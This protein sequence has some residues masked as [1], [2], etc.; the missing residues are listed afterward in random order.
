MTPTVLFVGGGLET[1][2]AIRRAQAMG[3]RVVVS[4]RDPQA[5]GC[6]IADHALIASAYHPDETVAAVA[7]FHRDVCR[8]DAALAVA[9]DCPHSVAAV[10]AALGLP[11]ITPEVGQRAVDKLAM[12]RKFAQDRVPQPW[13]KEVG[14]ADE[15]RKV[16]AS[17]GYPLVLKPADSRGARGV[18]R[19]T[20]SHDPAWAYRL[21]RSHSPTG[22]V[23]VERYVA[24]PQVSTESLVIDGTV[25][26]P[27]LS[28]RN[29]SR[30]DLDHPH[31]VEDG[32]DL[33]CSVSE[34]TQEAIRQVVA[35]A[36]ASLGV[37]NGTVKGDIVVQGGKPLVIEL[38]ARLSGGYFCTHEIPL[39]TGV[40]FIGA[41]LRHALGMPVDPADLAVRRTRY[42]SQRYI[43]PP[44]GVV[45]TVR[46][47]DA[48][49]DMPGIAFAEVRCRP[50]AI[51]HPVDCHPAR[52]GVVIATGDS[53]QQAMQ[54]ATNA[55]D[56][57]QITT[58]PAANSAIEAA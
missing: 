38:A 36:A 3:C 29:Y 35:R 46:G 20:G 43:F 30:L 2:P 6:Q 12:K 8:I 27:G 40:D 19:L 55:I 22:R 44:P 39:A 47:A 11:G 53:R 23:I 16:I 58:D 5:L 17:Q 45:Q 26:T 28:D 50:G 1:V 57:I 42:V 31:I 37:V 21:S 14:S 56:A 7:P 52:A 32:G 18:L 41:V 24:G 10:N 48:I 34:D 51:M 15:L 33:P 13:F 9:T 4:D 54:R 25:H 49:A